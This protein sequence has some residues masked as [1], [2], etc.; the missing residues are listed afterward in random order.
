MEEINL[1]GKKVL[2]I[3]APRDFRDEEYTIPREYLEKLQLVAL[4]QKKP[5]EDLV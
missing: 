4:Q 5:L 2:I 1:T 3:I